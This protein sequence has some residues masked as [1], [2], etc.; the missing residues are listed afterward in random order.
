M[1]TDLLPILIPL[2]I[3]EF[4]LAAATII[5][6]LRHPHYRFGNKW[7][8]LL[9]SFVTIIGPVLYFFIGRGDA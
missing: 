8:W 4:A 5:H 1:S 2:I 9:L 6:V 3:L 7:L